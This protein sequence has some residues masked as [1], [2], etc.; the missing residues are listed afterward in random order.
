MRTTREQKPSQHIGGLPCPK[1]RQMI[2]IS[3]QQMLMHHT[4]FC[5][6][7]GLRLDIDKNKSDKAIEAL[8]KIEAAEK[9]R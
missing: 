4:F 6:S 9:R 2:P 5:P 8:R 7:C 3:M 1:C